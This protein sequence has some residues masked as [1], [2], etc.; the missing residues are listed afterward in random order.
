MLLRYLLAVPTRSSIRRNTIGVCVAI[1]GFGSSGAV[2]G[3]SMVPAPVAELH[4]ELRPRLCTV[5][6]D[7]EVCS[8]RVEARWNSTVGQSLCL[9]IRARPQIIHCW[10]QRREGAFAADV[11]FQEDL[12]VELRDTD[13]Q[14]TMAS[15][16]VRVIHQA[17]EYR[18]KRRRPW[19]L[20][21]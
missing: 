4:L 21:D 1:L 11:S 6:G 20:F 19:S 15:A 9:V 17:T 8:A 16:S 3:D 14:H 18:R 13:L 7:E 10:T 2:F 12:L 5:R